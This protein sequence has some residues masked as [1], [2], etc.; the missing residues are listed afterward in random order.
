MTSAPTQ[1]KTLQ[2]RRQGKRQVGENTNTLSLE[3]K[4][5]MEETQAVDGWQNDILS[6]LIGHF[7]KEKSIRILYW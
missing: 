3:S 4:C 6:Y 7:L 2:E 1:N 5:E